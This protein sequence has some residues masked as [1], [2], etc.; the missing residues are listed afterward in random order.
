MQKPRPPGALAA[1]ALILGLALPGLVSPHPAS[2]Q[3]GTVALVGGMLLDGYETPPIHHAAV[4]IEGNRIVAVGPATEVEIP[5]G[6]EIISTEGMTMLPGLV[7]LHVHLM[8]LGHGE[9]SE[10]WPILDKAREE[11]MA[12]SAK[13]LL[14]AGVTTAVDLG[15]PMEILNVRDDINEDRLPGPRML[16]SGPWITR[17]GR[18]WPDWFQRRIAS[19]AEAAEQTN[20]LIDAGVDVIKIWAGM[21]E[22]DMRAVVEAAHRRGVEVHTHLYAP[23]DMWAAIRAGTDVIQ[24]AGSGGNPPY[25]DDLIAEVAHRGIP[26]VQTIAHRIWVYP[27][28]LEFPERLQDRRLKEDLPPDLYREFQ[29]SFEDFHRNS[30]FRTTPRQIRNSEIAARQFIEGGAVIAMGTDSGSPMNFHT[31]AAWREI[32]ALVD[33]GMTPLAAISASTK[34]GAEVI[35]RGRDLGTI[36]PGKLAD[37]IVVEGNPLFDINVLGY[38]RMVVKDGVRYK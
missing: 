28:T 3:D 30:Y 32:S 31:E 22:D 20:D 35:G 15:A 8:I 5:T 11:M 13:Q 24:H 23:E 34:T 19:P 29:R 37:I 21:T 12:I 17:A 18:Q 36:E 2:A 16:V 38:V 10:W 4:V 14:M 7:D 26:V 25:S 27:A 33:S 1:G 6:A 9:Y